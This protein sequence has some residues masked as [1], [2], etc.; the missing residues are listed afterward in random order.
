MLSLWLDLSVESPRLRREHTTL[1]AQYLPSADLFFRISMY[2]SALYITIKLLIGVVVIYGG[3][4][5]APIAQPIPVVSFASEQ[6][7]NEDGFKGTN[8]INRENML[9]TTL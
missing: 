5:W 7:Y 3:V 9:V 4:F 6:N 2:V 8:G 1:S